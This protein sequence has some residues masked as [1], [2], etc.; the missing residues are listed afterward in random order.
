VLFG[1]YFFWCGAGAERAVRAYRRHEA[2]VRRL[3]S[4]RSQHNGK[5]ISFVD[6]MKGGDEIRRIY[7][8]LSND[9]FPNNRS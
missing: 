7:A 9:R 3:K 5:E 2:C 8:Y 1:A 6:L 4:F